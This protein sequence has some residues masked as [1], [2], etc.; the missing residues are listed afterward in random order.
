MPPSL[1]YHSLN[2]TLYPTNH[3]NETLLVV[4]FNGPTRIS[5]FRFIPEG[6]GVGNLAS[7]GAHGNGNGNVGTTYPPQFTAQLLFNISPSNPVNALASTTIEV[8]PCEHALDYPIDMPI[9]VTTRMMMLR[10]PAQKLSLSIYGYQGDSLNTEEEQTQARITQ[11]QPVHSARQTKKV[12]EDFSWLYTW[13]G[14]SPSSLFSLLDESVPLQISNRAIE[15]LTL[16]DQVQAQSQAQPGALLPSVISLLLD[17]PTALKYLMVTDSLSAVPFKDRI[18][19]DPES[20]LHPNI[21]PYLPT[22]H[23]LSLISKAI[24]KEERHSNAVKNLSKPELESH[25]GALI[26]LQDISETELLNVEQGK[27]K[28][29]LMRLMELANDLISKI[30]KGIE[31]DDTIGCLGKI[32]DILNKSYRNERLNEYLAR[33]LPRLVVWYNLKKADGKRELEIP[34]GYSHEVIRSLGE[35]RS[36]IINGRSTRSV[37]D[38]LAGKYLD[39][40]DDEDPSKKIFTNESST[41]TLSQDVDTAIEVDADQRRLNRL[42]QSLLTSSNNSSSLTHSITPSELISLLSPELYKSLST[43]RTPPFGITPSVQSSEMEQGAKSFAGKVY[44]HHEFRRDRNDLSS[45]VGS[46]YGLGISGANMG[47]MGGLGVVSS[48]GGGGRAASRHVD[49]WTR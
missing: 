46:G 12:D 11:A 2:P 45:S 36:Q 1:I 14:P 28:S 16:L 39:K 15:C 47:G 32:L 24:T 31:R 34:L 25:L 42:S 9:G 3:A 23:P 41:Q 26:A 20:A 22:D 21:S 13:S 49:S 40:V 10:S 4:R 37:C 27:Q 29:N 35:I 5:S 44:T 30:D 48:A 19:S 6:V 33:N 7:Q 17:H 43:S 18:L 38:E 8:V